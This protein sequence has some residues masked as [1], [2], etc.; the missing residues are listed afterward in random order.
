MARM[1]LS[2][3]QNR[4]TDTESRPVVAEGQEDVERDALGVGLV[5]AI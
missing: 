3:K 5:D 1:N 2:T 4:L